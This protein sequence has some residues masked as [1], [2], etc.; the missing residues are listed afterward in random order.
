MASGGG[1]LDVSAGTAALYNTVVASNTFGTGVGAPASDIAGS[2]SGSSSF[3]LIGT[4]GSGGLSNGVNNNQVGVSNPLLGALASNG[5]PTQTIALLFKGPARRSAAAF[6]Q[7]VR[8]P[9]R[10]PTGADR[11]AFQ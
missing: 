10:L 8:L 2:V 5:G 9:Y 4:G 7:L 11:C 6:R 3:N 1:T